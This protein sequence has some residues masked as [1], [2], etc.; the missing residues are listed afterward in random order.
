MSREENS[1]PTRRTPSK[2]VHL[3]SGQPTIVW[4]TV[5]AKDRVPWIA[6]QP[7][8]DALHDIWLG[9]ATAWLVGDYLLMPDHLHFFCVPDRPN[10]P[11]EQWVS[12]WKDRF[13]RKH[14]D[15]SWVWQ[16]G[17]F[18]HR[19]HNEGEYHEKWIYLMQNPVRNGL[20]ASPDEWPWKGTVH[21]IGW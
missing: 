6:K 1:Q 16:R 12:F 14:S 7:V 13:S 19:V 3:Q 5:C 21:K 15:S 18:H 11:I 2:G 4:V 17:V 8:Q 9:T 10:F 20:V